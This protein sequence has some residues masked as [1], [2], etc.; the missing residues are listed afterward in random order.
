M[1]IAM[2]QPNLMPWLPFFDK[3]N[4]ADIFVLLLN[5]QYEKNGWQNRCQVNERYWTLPVNSGLVEINRKQYV[6]GYGL[7]SL[8]I[9]WINAIAMTLGIDVAKIRLDF[10][11]EKK[12]TERLI[13]LCKYY[14][15]DQYLTNPEATDKYLDDKAMNDAGIEV[16]PHSFPHKIHTFEA[17]DKWGI[18][19]TQNVLHKSKQQWLKK[20]NSNAS[21]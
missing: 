20:E 10:P 5:V 8:N 2:H 18:E 3:L 1:I 4:K 9:Q 16:L 15:C 19:G 21:K 12:G 17:F 6:N 14:E 11:T 7:P 13:E